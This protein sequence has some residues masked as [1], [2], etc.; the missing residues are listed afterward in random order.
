MANS[1]EGGACWTGAGFLDENFEEVAGGATFFA[2]V[3]LLETGA[4][5]SGAFGLF[6]FQPKI[7][8]GALEEAL[9]VEAKPTPLNELAGAKAFAALSP[10]TRTMA[11]VFMIAIFFNLR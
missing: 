5:G 10:A 8:C 4:G 2:G 1:V 6:F 9:V 7:I 3:P 11:E